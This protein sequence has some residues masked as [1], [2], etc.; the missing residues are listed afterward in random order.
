MSNR[1]K[2]KKKVAVSPKQRTEPTPSRERKYWQPPQA[3]LGTVIFLTLG[4]AI[5]AKSI[6]LYLPAGLI[7]IGVIGYSGFIA[8]RTGASSKG[9]KF[10]LT[11][12]VLITI[13]MIAR[14]YSTLYK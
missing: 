9:M 12:V 6:Y 3:L 13:L 1:T 14:I 4:T 5:L 10:I 8:N 11:P 7:L 2:I